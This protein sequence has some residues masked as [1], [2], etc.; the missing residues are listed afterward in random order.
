VVVSNGKIK[1]D[2]LPDAPCQF[3]ILEIES[4]K[5]EKVLAEG[6]S[7]GAPSAFLR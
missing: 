1:L 3:A 4:K 6:A 7:S 5:K 2:F